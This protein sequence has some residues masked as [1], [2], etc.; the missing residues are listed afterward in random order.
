MP[1]RAVA[2]AA[3]TADTAAAATARTTGAAGAAGAGTA[4]AAGAAGAARATA[5]AAPSGGKSTATDGHVASGDVAADAATTSSSPRL[6]EGKDGEQQCSGGEQ[7]GQDGT[8]VGARS[9]AAASRQTGKK[10]GGAPTIECG[11]LPSSFS[12]T[13]ASVHS[14]AS[15]WVD[16]GLS[17]DD[18]SVGEFV[19]A[20]GQLN[21]SSSSSSSSAAQSIQDHVLIEEYMG[22]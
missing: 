11:D 17:G 5:D 15:D 8:L 12:E 10:T 20:G 18:S 1:P 19:G 4:R 21:R 14:P 16:L 13:E 9:G 6:L 2:A 22:E 7:H 3:A